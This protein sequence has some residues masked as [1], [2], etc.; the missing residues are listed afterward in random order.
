VTACATTLTSCAASAVGTTS[1]TSTPTSMPSCQ[2]QF[3][4]CLNANPLNFLGCSAQLAGC[5]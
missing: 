5:H 2:Q 4:Q 3:T 1:P